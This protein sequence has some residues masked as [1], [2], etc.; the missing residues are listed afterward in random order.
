[1]SKVSYLAGKS[2]IFFDA[3]TLPELLDPVTGQFDLH[4]EQKKSKK[5][6]NTYYSIRVS[7]KDNT[8]KRA[9]KVSFPDGIVIDDC[10]ETQ[11][12][13]GAWNT[14][15]SEPDQAS[16]W[17]DKFKPLMDKIVERVSQDYGPE[18]PFE[19]EVYPSPVINKA[20]KVV[21][22]FP[23]HFT[24]SQLQRINEAKG[25]SVFL[26]I[27]SIYVLFV[28]EKKRAICGFNFSLHEVP[29]TLVVNSKKRKADEII[30]RE[31]EEVKV[32]E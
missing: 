19:F 8:T 20:D 4:L 5:A 2:A 25:A 28:K 31:T 18:S 17:A 21:T 30:S 7:Q 26:T 6:E 22:V 15:T 16:A 14:L 23:K 12:P 9:I 24:D 29:V 32:E 1:M 3:N 11:L 13:R 27:D 10:G